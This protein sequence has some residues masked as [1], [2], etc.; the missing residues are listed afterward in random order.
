MDGPDYSAYPVVVVAGVVWGVMENAYQVL[1]L[2]A[3]W[4]SATKYKGLICWARLAR[5]TAI[6]L[7]LR[8]IFG[9]LRLV[10]L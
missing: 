8:F 2:V 3:I 6:V 10:V 1:I 7:A 5:A 9:L 4:R